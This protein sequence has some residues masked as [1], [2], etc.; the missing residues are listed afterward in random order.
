[1][2]ARPQPTNLLP[3]TP[4]GHSWVNKAKDLLDQPITESQI[5]TLQQLIKEGEATGLQL[6][7]LTR[8]RAKVAALQ[9]QIQVGAGAIQLRWPGTRCWPRHA[10]CLP[11]KVKNLSKHIPCLPLPLSNLVEHPPCLPLKV[12]TLFKHTSRL[13]L[14]VKI[15]FKRVFEGQSFGE[16]PQ[17]DDVPMLQAEGSQAGEEGG[18]SSG[19][20]GSK[21][22]SMK[23]EPK[24]E[25]AA[26]SAHHETAATSSLANAAPAESPQAGRHAAATP[27]DTPMPDAAGSPSAVKPENGQGNPSPS[28]AQQLLAAQEPITL[29]GATEE[30]SRA[31]SASSSKPALAIAIQYAEIAKALPVDPKV[32]QALCD[33]VE[34]AVKFE[35][36][37]NGLLSGEAMKMELPEL[38]A[39]VGRASTM[40]F[41]WGCVLASALC[42]G[43][44]YIS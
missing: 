41:R 5:P 22:G 40:P 36:K 9:W 38:M 30:C 16:E 15:L 17:D 10:S 44:L 6:P 35:C 37:C 19:T 39:L 21:Q 12:E 20:A 7:E 34:T 13:P 14:Q 31:A 24:P 33:A 1:M 28:T 42:T 3:F 18:R 25:Q 8:V 11:L 26:E 27:A 2:V 32:R 23:A 4:A 29:E 43:C